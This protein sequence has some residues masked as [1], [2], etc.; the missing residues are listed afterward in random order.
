MKKYLLIMI[1]AAL[2]IMPLSASAFDWTGIKNA[3]SVLS[4]TQSNIQKNTVKQINSASNQA[5]NQAVNS[6]SNQTSAQ[7]A[8]LNNQLSAADKSA[9]E[10]FLSIVQ[11]L[12]SQKEADIINKKISAVETDAKTDAAAKSMLISQLISN[13]ASGIKADKNTAKAA[14]AQ[15]TQD[16][17]TVISNALASLSESGSQYASLAKKYAALTKASSSLSELAQT[18]ASVKQTITAVKSRAGAVSSLASAL[19]ELVK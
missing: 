18:A 9:Q 7:L 16:E 11:L 14:L 13:Y 15:M 12:S 10:S 19:S 3:A 2:Y 8:E 17:K 6:V 1:A 4:E 5:V